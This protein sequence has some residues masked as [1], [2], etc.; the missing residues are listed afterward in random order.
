MVRREEFSSFLEQIKF[1]E[2]KNRAHNP[3]IAKAYHDE[4]PTNKFIETTVG[5]RELQ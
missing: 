5:K 1:G 4:F 3:G 2:K